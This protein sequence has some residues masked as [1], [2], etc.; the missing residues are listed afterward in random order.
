M[1]LERAEVDPAREAPLRSW[2]H[3]RG[4]RPLLAAGS[5]RRG[6][7]EFVLEAFA[8]VRAQAP[9]ALLLGPR[10]MERMVEIEDL[11]RRAGFTVSRRT[12]PRPGADVFLLDTMGELAAAYPQ[13]VA[14]FLGGTLRHR[15]QNFVEP[16][17]HG[18]PVSFG[19][20]HVYLAEEQRACVVA[21]LGTRV[22]RPGDLARHWQQVLAA[23]GP[24][25]GFRSRAGEFLDRH[26]GALARTVQVILDQTPAT[27][28]AP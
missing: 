12:A 2:L 4:D 25:D 23:A 17:I 1:D 22:E 24:R 27:V 5:T 15:G 16:L 21:G 6:D 10:Q 3:G 11:V 9:C 20:A 8:A 7:E 18:L 19:P 14:A 26:R 13:A 28:P